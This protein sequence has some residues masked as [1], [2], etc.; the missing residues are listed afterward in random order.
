MATIITEWMP[1]HI[2][3]QG[4][5]V[6]KAFPRKNKAGKV[7]FQ[8]FFALPPSATF[9]P[10]SK[11]GLFGAQVRRVGRLVDDPSF[12]TSQLEYGLNAAGA[13]AKAQVS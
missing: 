5:N 13:V 10:F 3:E 12:T 6:Y 4:E 9:S 11:S 7:Y 2:I 1:K 8:G